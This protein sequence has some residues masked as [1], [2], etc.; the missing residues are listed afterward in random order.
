[1]FHRQRG[2]CAYSGLRMVPQ[3][4]KSWKASPERLDTTKGYIHGN[5]VLVC[6]EF[7]G[8]CQMSRDRILDMIHR[9]EIDDP[10]LPSSST[11]SRY[12]RFHRRSRGYQIST[13]SMVQQYWAQ[14]GRCYISEIPFDLSDSHY[15]PHLMG[16]DRNP[17]FIV[18]ALAISRHCYWSD[19]K[20]RKLRRA[21]RRQQKRHLTCPNAPPD[22]STPPC[23]TAPP[24]F[25]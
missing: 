7:N 4:K 21:V 20:F 6:L 23:L 2:R 12:F 14:H 13:E 16:T 15:W 1:M 22:L 17:V 25:D 24:A 3:S 9:S 8:Y 11:V 5:V 19:K 18:R 10:R